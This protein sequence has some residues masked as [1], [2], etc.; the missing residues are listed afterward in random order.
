ME[1][2]SVEPRVNGGE[3]KTRMRGRVSSS[4][5]R[6]APCEEAILVLDERER[7]DATL[8]VRDKEFAVISESSLDIGFLPELV[9]RDEC[10]SEGR[11][12]AHVAK[13][14]PMLAAVDVGGDDREVANEV[15]CVVASFDT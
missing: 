12:A 3:G 2:R 5:G 6:D 15:Y 4:G 11:D 7:D 9:Y 8:L 10:V 13:Q 14:D 1:L